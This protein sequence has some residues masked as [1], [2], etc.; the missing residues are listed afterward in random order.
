M[1]KCYKIIED[2]P[3]TEPA[4]LTEEELNKLIE[5]RI[6]E[7]IEQREKEKEQEHHAY[8][9]ER[10]WWAIEKVATYLE[11]SRLNEY[12][13]LIE[14]PSHWMRINILGG[15]ARGMGMAIG[16]SLLGAVVFLI[17]QEI[18]MMN[19]PGISNFIA[20]IL[21]LVENIRTLNP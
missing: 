18:V 5:K 20:Q 2:N 14:R 6:S 13:T 3:E 1:E 11:H 17:L 4:I 21:D 12:V 9:T 19:L 16:F 10:Q 8:V 7:R 15:I